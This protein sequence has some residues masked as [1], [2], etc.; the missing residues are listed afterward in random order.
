MLRLLAT[1][2]TKGDEVYGS[3]GSKRVWKH[4]DSVTI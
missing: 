2:S 1:I 3:H 4:T